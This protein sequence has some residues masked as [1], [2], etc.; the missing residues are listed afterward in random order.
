MYV[1]N[2]MKMQAAIRKVWYQESHTESPI[3][4]SSTTPEIPMLPLIPGFV[5]LP[6]S[7]L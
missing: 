4:M 1:W 7:D 6:K 5:F 2:P 3:Y